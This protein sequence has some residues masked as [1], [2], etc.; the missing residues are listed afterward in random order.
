MYNGFNAFRINF[1]LNA[2]GITYGSG[3][4]SITYSTRY[5][6]NGQYYNCP[7][8]NLFNHRI[9]TTNYSETANF[10]DNTITGYNSSGGL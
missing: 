8:E 3:T 9:N 2:T 1:T 10:L 7:A 4:Y 6:L 5:I